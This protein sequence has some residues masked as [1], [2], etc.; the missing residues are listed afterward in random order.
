[1]TCNTVSVITDMGSQPKAHLCLELNFILLWRLDIT[2]FWNWLVIFVSHAVYIYATSSSQLQCTIGTT[3]Y[4]M[5]SFQLET[6]VPERSQIKVD[7]IVCSKVMEVL[8]RKS[9]CLLVSFRDHPK[10]RWSGKVSRFPWPFQHLRH[11]KIMWL[12]TH[13]TCQY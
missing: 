8:L 13:R 10:A 9:R 3:H 1:M 5:I 6:R 11:L 2:Y 12:L 4:P 7:T